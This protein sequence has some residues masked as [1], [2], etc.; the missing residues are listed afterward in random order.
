LSLLFVIRAYLLIT[1]NA[2]RIALILISFFRAKDYIKTTPITNNQ[3]FL[4]P[5]SEPRLLMFNQHLAVLKYLR[6]SSV[7]F[8]NKFPFWCMSLEPGFSRPERETF[9]SGA[10][11]W[12]LISCFATLNARKKLQ[13][14]KLSSVPASLYFIDSFCFLLFRFIVD[15]GSREWWTDQGCSKN[16]GTICKYSSSA[17][18]GDVSCGQYMYRRYSFSNTTELVAS[19][20]FVVSFYISLLLWKGNDQHEDMDPVVTAR[21]HGDRNV[22]ITFAS[23]LRLCL[24]MWA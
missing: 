6:Y 17:Y 1:S 23:L 11:N 3:F 14:Y 5:I 18:A 7:C 9:A 8:V 24:V 13:Q 22:R 15:S 16:L 12:F 10:T 20:L 2:K 4:H 19:I 21:N